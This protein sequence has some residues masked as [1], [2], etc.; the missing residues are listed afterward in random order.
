MGRFSFIGNLFVALLKRSEGGDQSIAFVVSKH[1][2]WQHVV[3]LMNIA[4]KA[5]VSRPLL[6]L[7]CQ[8]GRVRHRSHPSQKR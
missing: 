3:S 7:M 5:G 1:V 4:K 8:R 2:K 6:Y